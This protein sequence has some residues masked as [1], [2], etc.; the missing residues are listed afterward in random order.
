MRSILASFV[1]FCFSIL[2]C[3][4]ARPQPETGGG[5]VLYVQ[6]AGMMKSQSGAT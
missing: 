6:V 4:G 5:R 1:L 3:S 2:A